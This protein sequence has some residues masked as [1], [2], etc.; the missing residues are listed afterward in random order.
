MNPKILRIIKIVGRKADQ[1]NLKTYL[2]GGI[3][4]DVL[5]K[6]N[7]L[8]IDIVVEG[9]GILLAQEIARE[10]KKKLIIY[11][12]FKTATLFW[13]ED[14]HIDFATARK[15][16]YPF[17]GALPV[18]APG[19]I[20]DDLF[21]RDFTINA[22]AI[23]INKDSFGQLVDE[24]GGLVDLQH[25]K[26]RI[27]HDKSFIEDPT[28]ILRAVRF[29]Q[30]FRFCI[31]THTLNLLKEALKKEL[32]K[33]VKA[34]RY[35]NEFKKMLKERDVVLCF[36]RLIQLKA[37]SFLSPGI[38]I[39][40]PLLQQ[41]DK[42]IQNLRR[43]SSRVDPSVDL[44]CL[45]I[46]LERLKPKA[47]EALLSRFNLR[48]EDRVAI[49]ESYKWKDIETKLSRGHL[50]PSE[51]YLILKPLSQTTILYLRFRSLKRI[52]WQRIDRFLKNDQMV[53]I[54]LTGEDIKNLGCTSGQKIGE[55]LDNVLYEKIDGKLNNKQQ[56]YKRAKE[57]IL[58]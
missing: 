18:V 5:L 50:K 48:R 16:S 24:F 1:K 2:V 30:R 10:Q 47:L 42:N 35:F 36:K 46:L 28:R 34:Q 40:L 12:Q 4:R 22:M 13:S 32:F 3:V 11:P 44:I 19:N 8:D 20:R 26:I 37:L 15:E 14:I 56:E 29:E 53:K 17:S 49:V 55:V 43:V 31:Q 58:L 9:S 57:L 51:G 33:N 21:R 7:N 23:S 39:N 38:K 25:K 45:M 27:L 52:V 54:F 6:R 41:I